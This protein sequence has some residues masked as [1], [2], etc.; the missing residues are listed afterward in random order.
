MP[1][2]TEMAELTLTV[3]DA[4]ALIATGFTSAT[5]LIGWLRTNRSGVAQWD[6]KVDQIFSELQ[7]VQSRLGLMAGYVIQLCAIA[8]DVLNRTDVVPSAEK[9]SPSAPSPAADIVA[10]AVANAARA[11]VRTSDER[12][13]EPK[14]EKL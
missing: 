3:T 12:T 8:R 7:L 10:N 1:V 4:Q 9:K 5:H 14:F 11:S 13:I 6:Q 2:T